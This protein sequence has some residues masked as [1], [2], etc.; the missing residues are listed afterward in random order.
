MRSG[1]DCFRSTVSLTISCAATNQVNSFKKFF[2]DSNSGLQFTILDLSFWESVL[3]DIFDGN[4]DV[5]LGVDLGKRPHQVRAE[6]RVN[7][8]R[9]KSVI[10]TD[11]PSI[12]CQMIINSLVID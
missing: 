9:V 5:E 10:Q 3:I 8:F 7:F 4:F 12:L 11:P 2:P 1:F 6:L